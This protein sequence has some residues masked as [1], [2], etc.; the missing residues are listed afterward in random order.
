MKNQKFIII[1]FLLFFTFFL[2]PLDIKRVLII[3]S[4]RPY[5]TWTQNIDQGIMET[6]A[7]YS[8]DVD[9]KVEYMDSLKS[10]DRVHFRL[11]FNLYKYKYK[12]DQFD[13]IICSDNYALNFLLEYRKLLFLDTPIVFCG[14]NQ[15]QN[16][17]VEG[18]SGI[19]GVTEDV[20]VED[21]L[22]CIFSIHKKIRKIILWSIVHE[23]SEKNRKLAISIIQAYDPSIDIIHFRDLAPSQILPYIKGLSKNDIVILLSVLRDENNQIIPVEQTARMI[24]KSTQA[25]VYSFFDFFLGNGIV[26]GK[27]TS[28]YE[29]GKNAAAMVIKILE[30]TNPED[31]P[32]YKE[33]P[34]KFLFDWVELHRHKIKVRW[35][36]KNSI[37]I[38]QDEVF[39]IRYKNLVFIISFLLLFLI[40]TI[41]ILVIR[42]IRKIQM[43]KHYKEERESLYTLS[44][45]MLSIAGFDGYFKQ[46]NPA[47][48][49]TLGWS[50]DELISRPWLDFVHPEDKTKTIKAGQKLIN[51]KKIFNFENR[52]RCK[53]G[54]YKWISW[55]SFPLKSRG[56]I[57]C[58]ARDFTEKKSL[59]EKLN[60]LAV[61][62]PLTGISNRR[63]FFDLAKK[64]I[65]RA[66]RYYSKLSLLMLDID[67]FKAINDTYG[68]L[69]GDLVL[70]ELVKSMKNILRENDMPCRFGGEE[71]AVLLIESGKVESFNVSE[72]IRKDIAKSNVKWQNHNIKFTVSIGLTLIKGND[73]NLDDIIHRADKALYKAKGNGKNRV[74][75]EE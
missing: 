37:I 66:K 10:V 33:S 69:A 73:E 30:G 9:I 59:E 53:D 43:E 60:K 24:S 34:N 45:D 68:H 56:L 50:L 61:T 4:Y 2:W 71:F 14:I 36:P 64:E 8:P 72:R 15:F 39:F 13:C 35:L 17:I 18:Y 22:K 44:L 40:T 70:K 20:D 41:F 32:I 75:I 16:S 63:S 31:I 57:F 7:D 25:P 27:L 48:E 19:T 49:Y 58:V 5:Y 38:N 28:G 55:N 21:T 54:S 47:W 11:L 42:L 26:G 67:D 12:Q 29:Q 3:H 62:D 74:E 46:L 65:A 51:N 52:Y 1:L 6:I 23:N